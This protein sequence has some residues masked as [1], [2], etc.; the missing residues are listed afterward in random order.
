[1]KPVIISDKRD[2][3]AMAVSA[4]APLLQDW[5]NVFIDDYTMQNQKELVPARLV[6]RHFGFGN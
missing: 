2:P 4:D 5:L 6:E 3:I 1:M